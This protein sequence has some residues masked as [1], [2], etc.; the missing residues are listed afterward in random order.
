MPPV[1][2]LKEVSQIVLTAIHDEVGL[3]NFFLS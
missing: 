1:L 2:I 3:K